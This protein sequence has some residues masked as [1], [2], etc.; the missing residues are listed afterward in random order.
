[1]HS[2]LAAVAGLGLR[3]PRATIVVALAILAVCGFVAHDIPISTSRYKLVS[4]DNP[5]Q[6]RTLRFFDRYGVPDAVILVVSGADVAT[7]QRVVDDI[8]A[9]CEKLPELKGRVLGHI[10]VADVA[11]LLFLFEPGALAQMRKR[12]DKQ[13]ADLIEGGLPA[14]IDAMRKPLDAA[15]DGESTETVSEEEADKRFR[16]LAAI[17]R[18]LD[19]QLAGGD[20]LEQLPGL[21]EKMKTPRG[22]AV[23]DRGYLVSQDGA[24]HLV[25]MFPDLPGA[26]GHE[27]K[28]LVESV[29]AIRDRTELGGA[30]AELTGL[31][32]LVADELV[33]IN[34]GI[35]QT[36]LATSVG[37]MLL[38]LLA[39][40]SFRYTVLA[41]LPL[42][43]GV[44][45]T[46]AGAR[47]LYGGLNLVTSSFISVLLALGIDFGVYVLSRYG[48]L[49]REGLTTH[50]AIRGALAKAGPGMLIGAATTVMAFLMTTTIEFTAFS[51]L[52]VITAVGLVLMLLVTFLLLPA[53]ILVA[54]RGEKIR[55]PELAGMRR[56]PGVLRRGKY[57]FPAA[58]LLLTVFCATS[59]SSIAFNARYFDFIPEHTESAYAL[60]Q[61]E[62]D[63]QLSPVQASTGVDGV[64]Q[65]R[66]MTAR[67]R[68]LPTVGAVQSATD[69]LPM[70]DDKKI[71]ALREGFAGAR[72]P[73]FNKLRNRNR[74]AKI[75]AE[76]V[77]ELDDS[78]DEIAKQVRE[79]T[80]KTEAIKQAQEA[81][82]ALLKRL[83]ALPD[84]APILTKTETDLANV[85][86]RAWQTAKRVATRG[87]YEPG[88]LPSVFRAR[89]MSKD[90]KGLAIYATPSGS[91][92]D[93]PTAEKFATDVS[94]VDPNIA[95]LAVS[96]H[97][98]IRMIREGFWRSSLLSAALVLVILLIGFRKL[99]DS[100]FA[101][102]PALL[103]VC[104]M[105][106]AMGWLGL[107]FN[108]ANVIVLPLMT[109]IGIDAGAHMMHRW[110]ESAAKR[111]GVADLD[112]V[113]RGTGSAVVMA[114]VTTATGF[115]ALM[116]GDYGGM[117][118]LGLP[119]TI[120]IAGAL[121]AAVVV[122]PALLV[123]LEMA[124]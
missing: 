123:A 104:W 108:V 102:L 62:F 90:G 57:L 3:A 10:G 82:R 122:L 111:N 110:R 36:S 114:S 48:E 31:P 99:G 95:G 40:R 68:E 89:F 44:L 52:G 66:L 9:E 55:S 27:V 79:T 81:S 23:D 124:D 18:A 24:Y 70:L 78:L 46:L 7:R 37:I 112:D 28:P 118:A 54:G 56:L 85:L 103:G 47:A 88:D 94:R 35:L 61:I 87:N 77:E 115:A 34:R 19:A 39:F 91:I 16:D 83:E 76:K 98:H 101:M 49:V 53:L 45:L 109:G 63:K 105:L 117:R 11:E 65:A 86:E 116:L 14:W 50:D 64:E 59:W 72:D 84:G 80:G 20:A 8:S 22:A 4:E 71:T 120:G 29:R 30:R 107:D 96:I 119:M 74:S 1:M 38:L 6:A 75:L 41:L 25:A 93:Q 32:A 17:L 106:G 121:V 5:F 100:L 51:E 92:W 15:I 43:V 69:M 60:R 21:E 58:A 26:E 12:F 113:I 97:E 13:P 42:G 67:L 33:A 73:D 2:V